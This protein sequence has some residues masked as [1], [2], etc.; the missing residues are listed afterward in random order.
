MVL[1]CSWLLFF[2]SGAGAQRQKATGR[3]TR[4]YSLPLFFANEA[5][6]GVALVLLG[7]VARD[8][9]AGRTLFLC[10]HFGNTLLLLGTLTLTAVWLQDGRGNFRFI[11]ERTEVRAVVVGLL[12]VLAIGT[13][14]TMAALG[15][16][17]FPATSLHAS[18]LQDFTSA[19]PALLHCRLLH[20]ILAIIA[21]TYVTWVVFKNSSTASVL[22]ARF[23]GSHHPSVHRNR[24][25][26]PECITP[27]PRLAPDP[28][29]ACR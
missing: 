29:F 28:A 8:Q 12:A 25:W 9:S 11:Q 5:L 13:T 1:R 16:T 7:H 6:L 21:G 15:D 4:R 17:L 23:D 10:L 24:D 19:G 14:G 22:V 20:P 18:V 3:A 2:C 26:P 27:R